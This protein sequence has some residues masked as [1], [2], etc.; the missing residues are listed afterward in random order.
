MPTLDGS[1]EFKTPFSRGRWVWGEEEMALF[2]SY[3][4]KQK[5]HRH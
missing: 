4:L 5:K 2:F 3:S 1:P